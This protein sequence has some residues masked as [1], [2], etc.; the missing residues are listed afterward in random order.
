MINPKT[1]I[2]TLLAAAV[3]G[4]VSEA[5]LWIACARYGKMI[6]NNE[7]NTLGYITFL[8]HI[9]S[10]IIRELVFPNYPLSDSLGMPL[11]FMTGVIQ[12][13]VVYWCLLVVGIYL[14]KAIANKTAPDLTA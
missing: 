5:A 3:L 1:K 8:F 7:W 13:F 2:K 4:A 14:W 10:Q 12:F 6:D 11:I 9:P